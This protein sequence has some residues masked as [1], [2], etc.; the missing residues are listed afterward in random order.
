MING[1]SAINFGRGGVG[2]VI[3]QEG[4]G[5]GNQPARRAVVPALDAVP[6]GNGVLVEVRFELRDRHSRQ[7]LLLRQPWV[8]CP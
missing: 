3:A 7:V 4:R 6:A 2:D 8:V 5:G 1:E